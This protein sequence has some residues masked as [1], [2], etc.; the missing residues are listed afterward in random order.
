MKIATWNVNSV[1]ARLPVISSW[2]N[3]KKPD[4]LL[5]QEL[6]CEKHNFPFTFFEDLGY[7][8]AVFGQKRLNGVAI[9]SKSP[10]DDIEFG[11]PTYKEDENARYIE[12]VIGSVR[13]A[14]VYVPNGKEVGS[15]DYLYKLSFFENLYKHLEDVF[16]YNEIC[17]IG[18]DFNVAP[19][20]EDVYDPDV[21]RD[22]IICS[23]KEREA[24]RALLNLGYEDALRIFN[25]KS[26]LFSWW[27]YRGK[28]FEMNRGLRIDHML[29]S[30]KASDS[31]KEAFID[32]SPRSLA[33]TS[34]H[35]PVVVNL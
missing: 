35:T 5:L 6:K 20:D 11:L 33:K 29:L 4:V 2:I 8:C 25:K 14:S 26:D 34:D 31:I 18:G 21:W 19:F 12:A 16:R 3:D 15:K 17:I 9:L 23:I 24:F 28:S 10:L 32:K 22:K 27:D 1:R 7:N 30:P 13:V